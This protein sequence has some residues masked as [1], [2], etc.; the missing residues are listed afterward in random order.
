[1]STETFA[2]FWIAFT[3]TLAIGVITNS[4]LFS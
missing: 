4:P 1:M 3:L 2:F